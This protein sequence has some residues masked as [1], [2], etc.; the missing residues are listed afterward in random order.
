M[1]KRFFS[2]I[3]VFIL[4]LGVVPRVSA[5]HKV[6]LSSNVPLYGQEKNIWCGAACGQMIMN[7]Y[8]NPSDRKYFQQQNVWNNIQTYNKAGEPGNWAT[9]PQGL[10]DTMRNLNPPPGGTWNIHAN[11]TRN[12]VMFDILYWMNRNSYPVATLVNQGQHWVVIVG[13]ET[14]IVPNQGTSPTLNKVTINDPWPV[15]QGATSTVTGNKWYS[16]Y[17]NGAVTYDPNGTWEGKYVAVIEP[18]ISSGDVIIE[19][20]ARIGT[21]MITPEEAVALANYYIIEL[22]L[23]EM[24][25]YSMLLSEDT[26]NLDPFLVREEIE[27]GMPAGEEVPYYYIVPYGY[28]YEIPQIRVSILVNAFT[29]DFEEVGAFGEP[30]GYLSEEDAIN[31]AAIELELTPQEME[32]AQAILLFT[33]SAITHIGIYPFWKVTVDDR[34]IYIDQTG[35][36]HDEVTPSVPGD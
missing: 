32:Q 17:W 4:L 11:A 14:D 8:P 26:V 36:A 33:P 16:S 1:S 31:I 27:I 13:Y 12:T 22:G 30:V 9:D 6:D 5:D 29:G 23:G 28:N 2:F 20:V 15:N 7:G 3:L 19:T 24:E 35:T 25:P 10:R 34:Y 18:P 21:E